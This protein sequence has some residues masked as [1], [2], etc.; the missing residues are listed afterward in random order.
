[1]KLDKLAL[2]FM[3]TL[4]IGG[5]AFYF[6]GQQSEKVEDQESGVVFLPGL[7]NKINQVTQV[8][9]T[10]EKASTH[11]TL[12]EDQWVVEEKAGYGADFSKVK[13]LLL[14]LV[15]LKTVESKTSKPENY[16]RLGVQDIGQPGEESPSKL[17][18][19]DKADNVMHTLI[20]GKSK[21]AKGPSS[22]GAV[23]VRKQN[24]TQSWLVS[25]KIDLPAK[26]TDWLDKTIIDLPASRIQSVTIVQSDGSK[27]SVSKNE[28][29]DKNYTVED[30]PPK[31]ELK[32]ESVANSLANA[33]Q[34][35]S[36]EDVLNRG[37]FKI[38]EKTIVETTFKTYDDLQITAKVSEKD[39]KHYLWFDTK[40][41]SS[42]QKLVDESSQLNSN[43]ALWVYEI[44]SFKAESFK[45]KLEDLIKTSE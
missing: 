11:L 7:M 45:K 26:Q 6:S 14:G 3:L 37:K 23:Y 20:V 44:Q 33:L 15:D 24:E 17:T 19:L 30:L 8:V 34:K 43:F 22:K 38:D 35:L 1:M 36:F 29:T 28:K 9:I 5:A 27:L 40:T 42:E 10:D 12:K 39:D 25:G 4:L 2:V 32:S 41:T 21:S 16:G 31:A 18:L 13:S